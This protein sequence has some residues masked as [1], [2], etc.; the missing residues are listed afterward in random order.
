MDITKRYFDL[1]GKSAEKLVYEL[2][3]KSFL[4]DWCYSNPLL[5]DGKE[6]CD[7]LVVFDQ[8]AV[9]WQIKD[10]KLD[11]DGHYK[12]AEVKK[13]LRQLSGARRQLFDLKTPIRLKNPRRTEEVFDPSTISEIYL[14]SVLMGEGEEFF[15]FVELIKTYT[16][17]VFTREFTQIILTELDTIGDFTAYLRS[18]EPVVQQDKQIVILGGEEELLAFYLLNGRSFASFEEATLV[19]SQLKYGGF[20]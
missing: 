11:K 8:V 5:P 3:V 13:N 12:E 16:V 20:G 10:L 15:S 6:L 4:T 18:K 19:V 9:I 2:A 7:L 14:I 17:H 1:K